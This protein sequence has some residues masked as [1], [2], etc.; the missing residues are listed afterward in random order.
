MIK[1]HSASERGKL[2]PPYGLLIPISSKGSF[3]C[4]IPDRVAHT[5]AFIIP[6]V[7][8]WLER[9]IAQWE[10]DPMTHCI[11]SRHSTT[12]LY[13]A[14]TTS[15]LHQR[16]INQNSGNHVV[17]C[18]VTQ[19]DLMVV[20]RFLIELVFELKPDESLHTCASNLKRTIQIRGNTIGYT[21]Q[22]LNLK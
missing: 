7:E 2:L 1:D 18:L 9:E 8:H 13:L 6:V 22:F 19:Y 17:S 12:E 16:Y 4:T 3:I 14:P 20:N 11:M 21:F 5:T 10:I 15:K